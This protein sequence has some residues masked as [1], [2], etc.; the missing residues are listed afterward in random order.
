VQIV[1]LIKRL[2]KLTMNILINWKEEYSVKNKEIDQQHKRL[3]DMINQ[4]YDSLMSNDRDDI[5]EQIIS[6]LMDYTFVHF[7]SEENY[8]AKLEYEEA[9][10]HIVEHQYFL[11]EAEKFRNVYQSQDSKLIQEVISFLQEWITNHI[12]QTDK[13]YMNC[14]VKGEVK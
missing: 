6:D 7:K 3:F 9:T 5:L 2:F 12:M 14:V 13:K 8:F 4:L 11:K 1:N 10:S